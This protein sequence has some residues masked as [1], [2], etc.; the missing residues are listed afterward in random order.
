LRYR[1]LSRL[2]GQTG[3]DF[4]RKLRKLDAPRAR[5]AFATALEG[6]KGGICV[7]LGANL[8]DFTVQMADHAA[9]VY[10]FEPDPWTA[11]RLRDRVSDL[12]GVEVIEAAA[13]AEDGTIRLYR[14][15]DFARDPDLASQSASVMSAKR[16]VD[17]GSAI[18]V[19][20][21]DFPRWL[22]AL[23]ADV[24][25][26]KIDI[27]GAEVAL[28]ERLFDS[29]ALSRVGH[30]FVETHE[31]RIP[32]LAARTEALRARATGMTRPVVNMDWK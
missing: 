30:L 16:N 10:A 24:A 28:L 18:E 20:Q 26:I 12:G 29:P 27:E 9:R 25:V 3:L 14:S 7:D 4:A 13:G 8:G 21:V 22:E 2:P 32:E 1:A 6:A 19:R 15:P 31:S 23:E 11:Q 5:A 17:V